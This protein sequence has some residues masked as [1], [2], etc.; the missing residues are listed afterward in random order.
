MTPL[1]SILIPCFNA[2]HFVAQA[3]ESGLAQTWPVKEVIVVDDGSTDASLDRIRQFDGLIHWET[4][5]NRG[6][7]ITR[8][9]LLELANG[10]WLQY[11]DADDFLLPQKVERQVGFA[12]NSPDTDIICSPTIWEKM[13]NERLFCV[14]TRFPE[15]RDAWILL[16][17]WYLPQTGGPL[18]KRAALTRVG[19]WRVGQP[20]C[21]EHELYCRLLEGGCRFEFTDDC[22]AVYRDWDHSS[23]VT[24]RFRSEVIRQ[25]LLI[26][27]RIEKC[28]RE[29]GELTAE[30]QLAVND[31]RHQ[32]ARSVW[33]S[34]QRSALDIVREIRESDPLF[35]PSQGPS[36]PRSYQFAYRVL[37]F[38]GAQWIAKF[39][40]SFV[41]ILRGRFFQWLGM[42]ST[43]SR[44]GLKKV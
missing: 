28:L 33:Q 15:P 18:W 17:H 16:A 29:R 10:E 19:G 21:Q 36:S 35:Y 2:E 25:R 11:L 8:N 4:G 13:E 22:L 12:R 40:R 44:L 23:R 31:A 5:P 26:Q 27:A 41:S 1:V 34:D 32:I 24:G 3:I 6:G 42:K 7:N 43:R 30:R 37:G 9:R 38:R 14:K 20:C 39:R